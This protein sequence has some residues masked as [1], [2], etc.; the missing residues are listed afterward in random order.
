MHLYI[1]KISTRRVAQAGIVKVR[2]GSPKTDRNEQ[3]C[4]HQKSH[5]KQIFPNLFELLY[6][7]WIVV[8]YCGFFSVASDGATTAPNLEPRSLVNFVPV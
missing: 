1:K 6:T 4:A 7:G 3:F 2:V 5:R 8:V